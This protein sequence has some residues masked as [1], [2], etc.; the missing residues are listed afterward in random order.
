MPTTTFDFAIVGAGAAGLQ[1]AIKLAEDEYFNDKS[2]AIFEPDSKTA[3]DRTWSFWEKET[4]WDG[5][6]CKSWDKALFYGEGKELELHLRPYK[7]KT[8]KS[9]DFY[10]HAKKVINEHQNIT[11]LAEQVQSVNGQ[12]ITTTKGEHKAS[13]IFDSRVPSAFEKDQTHI[14]LLQHFKGW[15]IKTEEPVFD[16][17]KI[18][19]M[20]YRIKWKDSTS[21]TYV[22]PFSPTEALVE[23]TLFNEALLQDEEYDQYLKEYIRDY[24]GI[25]EFEIT[26]VEQGVIPMSDYPFHKHHEA[27]VTKIGTAGGW[28]RPSS[29][30]SFK[31][32][33]RYTSMIIDNIKKGHH[34]SKGIAN[35]RFRAYDKLFLHVLSSHNH[36]GEEVFTVL[37]GLKNHQTIL[38]FLDEES[39]LLEDLKVTSSLNKP[40]FREAFF[41]NVF[42]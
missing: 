7:Y 41:K 32:S 18:T 27:F 3:N 10:S 35:S 22:L 25:S 20:D 5:I 26:E 42:G 31:N 6:A 30:Y 17:D 24:I 36:K 15:F 23:F 16:V 11:W 2:I 34:P 28:V 1:L 12:L 21:F 39:S 8:I 38:R 4:K 14:H 37:Y 19:V 13:H 9:S 29:G 33:D 40:E